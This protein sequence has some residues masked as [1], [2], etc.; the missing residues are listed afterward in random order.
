MKE[1]LVWLFKNRFINKP[2][3]PER[4]S[5]GFLFL[6]G[7]SLWYARGL[8]GES[9]RSQYMQIR[10]FNLKLLLLSMIS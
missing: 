3:R 10:A 8:S 6:V 2:L 7:R 1:V 9:N 5:L 4:Y